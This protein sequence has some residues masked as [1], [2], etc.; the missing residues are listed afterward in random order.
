[1]AGN[2]LAAFIIS[3]SIFYLLTMKYINTISTWRFL[4]AQVFVVLTSYIDDLDLH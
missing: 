4:Q 3:I 2:I 1:M